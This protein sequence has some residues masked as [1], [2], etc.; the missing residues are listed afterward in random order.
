[1]DKFGYIRGRRG[2]PGPPGKN[3][4]DIPAWCPKGVLEMFRR[5]EECT[6]YFNTEKDGILYDGQKPIG[7]KDRFGKNNAICQQNHGKMIKVGD[8]Y[9]IEL[10]DSLY[11]I[12]NVFTGVGM[13]SIC[14]I[15]LEFKVSGEMTKDC[16]II[17]N[18]SLNRGVKISSESLD[19]LGTDAMKLEYESGEW[20]TLVIQYSSMRGESKCF[21]D[22]NDRRGS[23]VPY[24]PTKLDKGI[25]Y[26]GGH[27]KE[28]GSFAKVALSSLEIYYNFGIF[29]P[30]PYILPESILKLIKNDLN[31]KIEPTLKPI[32]DG[33]NDKMN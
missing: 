8:V 23:F 10:K 5:S 29:L 14:V 3:A 13:P 32:K 1:M 28:E 27:P 4:V 16:Y 19:I 25:V 6:F 20:N 12:S 33:L 22:L 26:I 31:D 24:R 17:C 21:F 15:A 7:L 11:K 2:P 18:E 30:D 9:G